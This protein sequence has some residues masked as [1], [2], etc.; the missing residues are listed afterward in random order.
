D[1]DTGLITGGIYTWY[2]GDIHRTGA[3]AKVSHFADDFLGSSHDLKFGV[4]YNQGGTDYIRGVNDLIY[5]Y[6]GVPA[7]GY[8]QFPFHDG[9]Q[10]RS[11]GVFLDDT[12]RVGSRLSINAGVRYDNNRASFDPQPI[13]DA[14]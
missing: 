14:N 10:E 3:S 5:S 8:T 12:I 1:L 7:F 6:G 9:G 2:D 11:L 13:L 4:Q